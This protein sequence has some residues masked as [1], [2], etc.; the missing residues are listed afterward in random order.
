[1]R[2]EL[3]GRTCGPGEGHQ[4]LASQVIEEVADAAGDHLQRPGGEHVHLDDT[5]YHEL[6]QVGGRGRG[7]D[8]DR[9]AGKH[10]RRE[11]LEHPP[12]REVE[13]V[14]LNRRALERYANVL[15]DEGPLL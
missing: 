9:H 4:V 5:P 6:G 15:A 10:S 8:D 11:L 1:V 3:G 7:L 13:C 14:D 2:P 12:D